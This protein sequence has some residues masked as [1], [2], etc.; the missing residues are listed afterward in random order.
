MLIVPEPEQEHV[1]SYDELALWAMLTIRKFSHSKGLKIGFNP[2]GGLASVNHLHLQINYYEW[3]MPLQEASQIEKAN[4]IYSLA[5]YPARSVAFSI[6][7]NHSKAQTALL[8]YVRLLQAENICHPI[9]LLGD[10]IHVWPADLK[11]EGHKFMDLIGT[12]ELDGFAEAATRTDFDNINK[13]SDIEREL[14]I[15]NVDSETFDWLLDQF[16]QSEIGQTEL[17]AVEESL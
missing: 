5:D 4:G 3:T 2:W 7:P 13:E 17:V 15:N 14:Q 6:T 9:S 11:L 1:Q 8:S 12:H 10:K 16:L